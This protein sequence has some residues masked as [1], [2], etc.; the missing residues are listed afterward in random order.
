[1]TDVGIRAPASG[2]DYQHAAALRRS[3][4]LPSGGSQR[5]LLR[6]LLLASAAAVVVSATWPIAP[7]P[8][9]VLLLGCWGVCLT[10]AR[11]SETTIVS[12]WGQELTRVVRAGCAFA[13]AGS[14]LSIIPSASLTTGQVFAVAAAC[15]ALS[16]AV[17]GTA[18]LRR[19]GRGRVLVVGDA[20]ERGHVVAALRRR[21][22]PALEVVSVRLESGAEAVP[23]GEIAV[24]LQSVPTYARQIG[25][26]SVVAV[27]G[28]CLDPVG[29]RRL[30][31]SLEG[32]RLPCFVG[33]GL[34]G[35]ASARIAAADVGGLPLVRVRA[36]KRSGPAWA[37][38][39]WTGRCLATVALIGLLPLLLVL[40]I[41]IRRESKGPAVFRQ[42]RVGKDGRT[43]TMF[44]LRTMVVEQ[45]SDM[46]S[47][48][49]DCD[50]VLF[51]MRGD[52]RITP[53][54]RWLRKYSLDEL[55][56]L[57]NVVLGQMRLVGP[58]PGLPAEV[59]EYSD[60]D[61]RRLA[62]PPGITGLW[63]VSGRSDLSW[64]ESVRLDLHYV[65]NWSLWL[66][67][68]ILCRTARAVLG[69]RGAY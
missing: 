64:E 7:L 59:A 11:A 38:V 45:Q 55:P 19:S 44:K 65:D 56:Q 51:K 52:P 39:D 23:P 63:Q 15:T 48:A 13:L 58:R 24:P 68:V 40:A 28:R 57:A 21:A 37:L 3:E 1:L 25:A 42:T 16:C 53:L 30:Q 66:D 34:L 26:H 5:L 2:L 29:L 12:T 62:V 60:D 14:A 10:L 35:V 67:L 46:A 27:P 31:W 9:V 61:R 50:G 20:A 43:F 47:L 8:V 36:A 6:D 54:G 41:A 32:A 17:R 4:R 22:G 49:N 69:H 33:T 18:V